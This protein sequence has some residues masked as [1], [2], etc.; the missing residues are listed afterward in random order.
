[1]P[2]PGSENVKVILPA[3]V[4]DYTSEEFEPDEIVTN[5]LPKDTSFGQRLYK[6]GDGLQI[7]LN[8]VLMGTDRTSLHKPQFCLEGGGWHIDQGSGLTDTVHLEKP[9]PYD[10]PVV[11]LLSSKEVPVNGQNV[12]M[13]GVYVY[14]FV[15]DGALSAGTSGFERMWWMAKDLIKTGVLQRWAYVSYFS[16]CLPGQEQATYERMK[17]FIAA[18]APEF[19]LTPGQGETVTA[20]R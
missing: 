8:V 12:M 20:K 9:R 7:D 13:R 11:R 15:A 2:I 1:V 5:T 14:Y 3:R 4:L 6:A 17:T 19:H 16:N 10:L 18:A